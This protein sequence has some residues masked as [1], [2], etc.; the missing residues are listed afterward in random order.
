M[1]GALVVPMSPVYEG[2]PQLALD[3]MKPLRRLVAASPAPKTDAKVSGAARAGLCEELCVARR[4]ENGLL[5]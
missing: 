4:C 5:A 3:P 2:Q 1:H